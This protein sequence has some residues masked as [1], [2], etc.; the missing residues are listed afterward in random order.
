MRFVRF[1]CLIGLATALGFGLFTT[2]GDP[3]EG[4]HIDMADVLFWA[5]IHTLDELRPIVLDLVHHILRA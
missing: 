5:W 4:S 2:L 3:F 1:A